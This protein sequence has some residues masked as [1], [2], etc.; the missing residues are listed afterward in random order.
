MATRRESV[1]IDV[2]SNLAQ[3]AARDAAAVKLL[4]GTLDSVSKSGVQSDRATKRISDGLAGIAPAADKADRSTKRTRASIDQL[5][6]RLRV[7]ADVAAILGPALAPIGAVSAVGITGLANQLG[8]AAAAGGTAILAFQGVGDAVTALNDYAFAPTAANALKVEESLARL[9]PAAQEFATRLGEMREQ[10]LATRDAAAT[11]LFPE[12]TPAM[13]ELEGLLGRVQPVLQ[14]IG[15]ATGAMLADGLASLNSDRWQPFFDFLQ[16]EARPVLTELGGT[17]GAFAHGLSELWMAFAPLNRDM[18]SWLSGIGAGFDSWASGLAQTQGFQDFIDY[19]RANGP[20]MA[21]TMGALGRALV[22]I[23]TAAAPLGGPALA[24][25]EAFANAVSALADSDIG[26]PI[27]TAI[28]AMALFN[29][30]MAVGRGAMN[31]FGQTRGNL[32]ALG[33]GFDGLSTRATG[34][35]RNMSRL[36]ATASGVGAVAVAVGVL[37]D[38]LFEAS[39]AK[40]DT[41][42]LARDVEALANGA[43]PK[44]L[45]QVADSLAYMN[46]TVAKGA[47]PFRELT[48]AFGLFWDTPMDKH[49]AQLKDLDQ[50]LAGLVESGNADQAAAAFQ[51]LM[52]A[53]TGAPEGTSFADSVRDDLLGTFTGYATALENAEAANGGYTDSTDAAAAA[54]AEAKANV[55]A[56]AQAMRVQASE[57]L[58]AFD[59][60]TAW[61]EAVRNARELAGKGARGIDAMTVAGAENRA[62]LSALASAWNNQSRAV[63][64]NEDRYRGARKQFIDTATA[65]GVNARAARNM[66]DRYLEVPRE[67][68]TRAELRADQVRAGISDVMNRIRDL[69]AQRPSPTVVAKT[70]A[71]AADLGA[72][73]GQL[74]TAD[75]YV[76]NSYT[77]HYITTIRRAVGA[78]IAVGAATGAPRAYGGPVIGVG[79][80][81]SD[82]ILTPTSPGEWVLQAPAVRKYGEDFISQLNAMAIPTTPALPGMQSAREIAAQRAESR[83]KMRD[84]STRGTDSTAMVAELDRRMRDSY[85]RE[86]MRVAQRSSGGA[87]RTVYIERTGPMRIEGKL[88][89]PFGISD[90]EGIATQVADSRIQDWRDDGDDFASDMSARSRDL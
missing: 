16:S 58:G 22:D 41:A 55:N 76:A 37:G 32:T 83:Q 60:Q 53:S 80:E 5:T 29:R 75:G 36:A 9:S 47:E 33:S 40:I 68:I 71:A 82:N 87:T 67:V 86:G 77:N 28:A 43:D 17:V 19:V 3:V 50:Q 18:S 84:L 73:I 66:A 13:N 39:G 31:A 65:M 20:Q 2:E 78:G 89:T 12:L 44:L 88:K 46:S 11:G 4:A 62:G 10:F 14:E 56:L 52:E 26:T 69:G 74:E 35:T 25:I 27:F 24:G 57:A 54:A 49:T 85:E 34:A 45:E 64:N 42:N 72:L 7:A 38:A 6:G 51:R 70:A 1:R 23:V 90:I 8:F 63:K 15:S 61:G 79:T 81:R 59:A 30:A 48:S 21:D